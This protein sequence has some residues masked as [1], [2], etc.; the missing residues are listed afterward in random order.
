[1]SATAVQP[2]VNLKNI[3]LPASHGGW[4]FLLEPIMLGLWIAP[5]LAGFWLGIAALGVFLSQ[6]PL[7]LAVTDRRKKRRYP[8]SVWAE[9]FSLFYGL[10]ALGG[11]TLAILSSRHIFWPPLLMAV[12][13][14]LIQLF[15]DSQNRGRELIPELF[16]AAALGAV[17]AAIALAGGWSMTLALAVWGILLARALVSIVYVRA[18]LRLERG[19]A[20]SMALV[21]IIHGLGVLAIAA[22]AVFNL[23]PWPAALAMVILLARAAFG[24]SPYRKPVKPQL[25]GFQ[26][27]GYGLL[28]VILTGAGY[29]LGL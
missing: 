7:R 11:L 9:R 14:A 8:R 2:R 19:I 6:Q 4:G 17:A 24:L 5:S 3:A 26:E 29:S 12:P 25:V 10:V 15:Y 21:F 18:R 27:T 28:T 13:P 1:M 22:P 20:V 16:G 23:A